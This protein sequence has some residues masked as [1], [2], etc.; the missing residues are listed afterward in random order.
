VKKVSIGNRLKK[1]REKKKL[2]QTDVKKITNINNKTLSRYENNGAEPDYDTLKILANLYGVSVAYLFGEEEI[3]E[4]E[5][6][7]EELLKT[8]KIT[9]GNE[10]LNEEESR[11]AIEMLRLLLDKQKDTIR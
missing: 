1:A 7:L 2:T 9:W 4:E 10:E 8:K 3:I 5:Y 11:R 6:D